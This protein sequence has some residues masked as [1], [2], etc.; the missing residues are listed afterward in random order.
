MASATLTDLLASAG[1]LWSEPST[2]EA[3]GVHHGYRRVV[4]VN[5]S[6]LLLDQFGPLLEQ[7]A[8]VAEAWLSWLDPGGFVVE[9]IDP[10]PHRE[11]WQI[12]FTDDGALLHDGVRV[13]HEVGVP[14]RVNHQEWHSVDSPGPGRPRISLVVDRDVIVSPHR[15]PLRLRTPGGD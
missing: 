5:G 13:V 9:H 10:G 6:R 1:G 12:P 15:S 11:R 3:T 4:V 14:F 7:F 2:F 8:P